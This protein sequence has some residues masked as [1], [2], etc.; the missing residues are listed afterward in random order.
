MSVAA[1][2][3]NPIGVRV[4]VYRRI[5]LRILTELIILAWKY[6]IE[7]DT[8][9]CRNCKTRKLRKSEVYASARNAVV[10]ADAEYEYDCCDDDVA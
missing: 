1:L 8:H 10:Y 6:R 3:N 5:P 2:F 7:D 4:K 9:Q